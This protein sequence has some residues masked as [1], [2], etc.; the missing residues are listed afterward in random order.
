MK[1]KEQIIRENRL[2]DATKKNYI[3]SSGK[4]A[5]IAKYLGS[6]I[7]AQGSRVDSLDGVYLPSVE[8]NNLQGYPEDVY[9]E[10]NTLPMFQNEEAIHCMGY[11]F[12]G[13]DR[14]INLE[15]NYFL[16]NK[17]LKVSYKGYQVFHEIEGILH[18]YAPFPEWESYIETFH[19]R[20]EINKKKMKQSLLEVEREEIKKEQLNFL[21]RLRM[22]WGI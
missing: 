8:T 2:I 21:D 17:T 6:P 10:E 20:A 14:G 12:C 18:G 11:T 9:D 13:M 1:D 3:G 19:K 15:I 22:V 5:T 7:I 4:L 16:E